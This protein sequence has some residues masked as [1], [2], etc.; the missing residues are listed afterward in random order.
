MTLAAAG[1]IMRCLLRHA[2]SLSSINKISNWII[3]KVMSHG[4]RHFS[5]WSK[6][7]WNWR[8][9][10]RGVERNLNDLFRRLLQTLAK[11]VI[12]T[13]DTHAAHIHVAT[14][15]RHWVGNI[16]TAIRSVIVHRDISARCDGIIRR[17]APLHMRRRRCIDKW[18]MDCCGHLKLYRRHWFHTA[19]G[20]AM[21]IWGGR[22]SGRRA[23]RVKWPNGTLSPHWSI[24][25]SYSRG[26]EDICKSVSDWIMT[27]KCLMK[28]DIMEG[29]IV[30]FT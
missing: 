16:A 24:G 3:V 7:T 11:C 12:W 18:I 14:N 8:K 30:S 27:R 9:L 17:L 15:E 2:P 5:L 21:V 19:W 25:P 29:Y 28:R 4:V 20:M 1:V 26:F 22:T 10:I 23:L 6:L 13:V